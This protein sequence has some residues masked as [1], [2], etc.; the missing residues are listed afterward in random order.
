MESWEAFKI[1]AKGFSYASATNLDRALW[2]SFSGESRVYFPLEG[3]TR[4][5]VKEDGTQSRALLVKNAGVLELGGFATHNNYALGPAKGYSSVSEL[6][7]EEILFLDIP[8]NLRYAKV[9][10]AYAL[11]WETLQS[12]I[13]EEF[14]FLRL[15]SEAMLPGA[16]P[17]ELP[18]LEERPERKTKLY[19]FY[20]LAV[21]KEGGVYHFSVN[22]L[23]PLEIPGLPLVRSQ[24]PVYPAFTVEVLLAAIAWLQSN[25]GEEGVVISVQQEFG[26]L[27]FS[28]K[29]KNGLYHEGSRLTHLKEAK[30]LDPIVASFAGP[31]VA[32][33]LESGSVP[34]PRAPPTKREKHKEEM[35]RYLHIFHQLVEKEM[36]HNPWKKLYAETE[37]KEEKSKLL[38][39]VL[40][41]VEAKLDPALVSELK[42][43]KMHP[44][45]FLGKPIFEALNRT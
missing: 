37:S 4:F 29:L 3:D 11:L 24:G 16:S 17:C 35:G 18:L 41:A 34:K 6:E 19:L 43:K 31:L 28:F 39:E 1:R 45:K 7:A 9:F 32:F 30:S 26:S 2:A 8:L 33:L 42:A 13:E 25:P 20:V 12:K 15:F 14:D 36:S 27:P 5:S 44:K 22:S 23:A 38:K 10:P 40:A 21:G